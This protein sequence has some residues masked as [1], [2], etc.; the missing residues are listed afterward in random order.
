[1][2]L[3]T[4][5]CSIKDNNINDLDNASKDFLTLDHLMKEQNIE[6]QKVKTVHRRR[7]LDSLG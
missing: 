6:I 3:E 7:D 2:D 1:M 5:L 4:S